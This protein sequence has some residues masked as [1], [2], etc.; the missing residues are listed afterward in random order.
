[1]YY[2]RLTY[3]LNNNDILMYSF[4]GFLTILNQL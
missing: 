4:M 3:D 2:F 1:M